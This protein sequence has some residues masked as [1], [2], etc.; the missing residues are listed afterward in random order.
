MNPLM[1]IAMG[2]II[3]LILICFVLIMINSSK[4]NTLLDYSE[5]GDIIGA[6]KEYYSK[7][8]DLAKTVDSKSDAVTLSRLASCEREAALSF[9]KLGVVNFDA[10]DDVKGNLSFALALLNSNDDGIILTSLY[11][12]NSCNTYVREIRGGKAHIKLLSEETMALETAK[13]KLK[14]GSGNGEE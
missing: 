4:I 10:Y 12:H 1:L 13:N 8:D 5:E 14:K 2:I 9:K 7:I 3:I 6:L 11:G